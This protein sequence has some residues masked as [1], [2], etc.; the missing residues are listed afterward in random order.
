MSFGEKTSCFPAGSQ[1]HLLQP[2]S[3]DLVKELSTLF[4]RSFWPT[5]ARVFLGLGVRDQVFMYVCI[6]YFSQ[7]WQMAEAGYRLEG[8]LFHSSGPHIL[9]CSLV[10]IYWQLDLAEGKNGINFFFFFLFGSVPRTP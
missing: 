3:E 2:R 1:R 9:P 8:Y 7:V 10:F 6:L 5:L 4:L